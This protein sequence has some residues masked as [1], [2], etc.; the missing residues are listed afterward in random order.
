MCEVSA[1]TALIDSEIANIR[2]QTMEQMGGGQKIDPSLLPGDLFRE[3]ANRR[4]V[5]GLILGEVINQQELKPDPGKVKEAVEE[6]ASTYES[7]DEVV[8]W[9]YGNKE[10]LA[11][12]ESSVL[13]DQVFDYILD[14]AEVTE[15]KVTYE[16]VI[17]AESP[18]E[19]ESKSDE[20]KV[21]KEK[22]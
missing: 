10:Q 21:D 6:I 14:Q 4:V 5:S 12:V 1:P 2:N 8:N 9:Y 16:E 19:S 11:T 17:Q 15:T 3:Q 20:E 22:E 7:P 13:E 18:V